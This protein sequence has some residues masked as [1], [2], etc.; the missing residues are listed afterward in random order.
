MYL[1]AM[2]TFQETTEECTSEEGSDAKQN[3][4]SRQFEA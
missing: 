2:Q 3:M 4:R 1:S